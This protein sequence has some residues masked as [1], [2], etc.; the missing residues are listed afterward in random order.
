MATTAILTTLIIPQAASLVLN[1]MTRL[2]TD[3][4]SRLQSLFV[5]D[6]ENDVSSKFSSSKCHCKSHKLLFVRV[7]KFSMDFVLISTLKT[8]SINM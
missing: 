7:F 3:E 6:R 4:S 8:C 5:H 2:A 1:L